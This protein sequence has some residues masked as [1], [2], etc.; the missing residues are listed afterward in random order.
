MML[1]GG[2]FSARSSDHD[3]RVS[4]PRPQGPSHALPAAAPAAYHQLRRGSATQ[5]R[6]PGNIS[7][8]GTPPPWLFP[9]G[10]CSRARPGLA[11]TGATHLPPCHP[12]FRGKEGA[13]TTGER[14]PL[15][16]ASRPGSNLVRSSPGLSSSPPQLSEILN[17]CLPVAIP[18]RNVFFPPGGWRTAYSRPQIPFPG[19]PIGFSPLLMTSGPL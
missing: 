10:N 12:H 19:R 11:G 15:P 1:F 5:P 8:L 6:P 2:R 13:M 17:R 3:P 14:F 4:K 16:L 7:N 9:S 18:P